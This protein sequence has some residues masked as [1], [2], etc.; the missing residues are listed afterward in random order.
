MPA[1][2]END[3]KAAAYGEYWAGAGAT[4]ARKGAGGGIFIFTL[5]TGGGGGRVRGG[6]VFHGD[7]D[8]AGEVGHTVAVANGE[9]CPCGQRGCLER[10][11]SANAVARRAG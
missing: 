10:Y 5:G 2:L 9:P 11:C 8:F 1:V 6:R 7:S 3:A 4:Q